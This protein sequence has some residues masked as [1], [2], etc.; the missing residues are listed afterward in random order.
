MTS[1]APGRAPVSDLQ[2]GPA[3][4]H[5]VAFEA[6]RSAVGE[7]VLH[8]HDPIFAIHFPER[9]V[10]PGSFVLRIAFAMAA[11]IEGYGA[12]RLGELERASFR[13]GAAPGTVLRI[14]V[15]RIADQEGRY[16][17]EARVGDTR[18]A[19]GGFAILGSTAP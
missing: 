18:I 5:I 9:P 16:G 12:W 7:T 13:Q 8:E 1:A 4:G 14:T 3:A 10:L 11:R 6:R 19:D 2:C 17:F 15:H